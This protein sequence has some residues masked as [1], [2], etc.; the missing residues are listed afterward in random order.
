MIFDIFLGAVAA[1]TLAAIGFLLGNNPVRRL[2]GEVTRWRNAA[3]RNAANVN[4]W[5][6]EASKLARELD[7]QTAFAVELQAGLQDANAANEDNCKKIEELNFRI[8]ML[9]TRR[10]AVESAEWKAPRARTDK[11]S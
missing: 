5:Q 3:H 4:S 8:Q 1:G 11:P 10:A 6:V 9:S 7:A 2:E